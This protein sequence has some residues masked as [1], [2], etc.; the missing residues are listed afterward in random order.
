MKKKI[1][2]NMTILIAISM[3]VMFGLMIIL[4][5]QQSRQNMQE[6]V[7]TEAGYV[8]LAVEDSGPLYLSEQTANVSP[9]RLTLI[10]AD[11]AVLYDSAE[12]AGKMEN[13]R[14]RPEVEDALEKGVGK[15]TRLSSTMGEVTYYYALKLSNGNVLRVARTTES[16]FITIR[17]SL[18]PLFLVFVCV[19]AIAVLL[20]RRQTENLVKPL[21][22]LDLEHP[23]ENDVYEEISPLLTR[24]NQQNHQ[25]AQQ[26][27]TLK[28]KQ[29]EYDTIT[30]NMQDGLIV[31][32][33][34]EILSI[35]K[36]ALQL[37]HIK[38]KECL[39][40]NILN[41][42][43]NEDLKSCLDLA[44]QGQSNNRV[45]EM[46]GGNYQF[47]GNPVHVDNEIRGAVI[48]IL[49]VT[50]KVQNEKMRREFTG[51]VSHELKTPLMSISGYAEL[52]MNNMV[53]AERIPEFAGRI[54]QEANRL[55]T[56]VADIL[57]LS[58]LDEQEDQLP[59]EEE[60][61]LW[62]IAN[63]VGRR[64]Q[65]K[66]EE[67]NI[68]VKI[69]GESVKIRGNRQIL[70]EIVYNLA[71]NAIKYNVE[72][73]KVRIQICRKDT[74]AEIEVK[75]SGRGIPA[76]DKERI[77]ERFY[78]VDKSRSQKT[79]GT[80]LGL[81]IVKHGVALHGGEIKVDSALGKGTKIKVLFP[82]K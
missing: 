9:S 2:K 33:K 76:A 46:E 18:F 40:K 73:G 71:D 24:I 62:M 82:L 47:L 60:V 54:H 14:E 10:Q 68:S 66:A 65:Q 32:D 35:N 64:L 8:K 70:N 20:T 15:S 58:R 45:V 5:D 63:D 61:D 42:S 50:Q 7:Q 78:R 74:H 4:I 51:N 41:F 72:D 49:D 59:M 31:T 57:K 55:S 37:F 21:N 25:I 16:V 38:K 34:T 11:G 13:H 52:I 27:E 6:M 75:D 23:L 22:G 12:P 69:K 26:L 17:N 43:R 36:K 28:E 77:F 19:L 79:E 48:F 29:D 44:L 81:S 1:L 53:S 39:H 56:L 67:R 3:L 80:G 30:E